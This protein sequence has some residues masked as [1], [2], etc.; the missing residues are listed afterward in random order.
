MQPSYKNQCGTV[1]AEING[2]V[3]ADVKCSHEMEV[4]DWT[5]ILQLTSSNLRGNPGQRFFALFRN[6]DNQQLQLSVDDPSTD[7]LWAVSDWFD[8]VPGEWQTWQFE[9][10]QNSD[11]PIMT[12]L[13]VSF[14]GVTV[15]S[16]SVP[17]ANVYA[18][19]DLD[20]Y[21]SNRWNIAGSAY[22][23][24]NFYYQTFPKI[25]AV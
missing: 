9:R 15:F 24:R 18:D 16:N 6:K 17:T 11:N 22:A 19:D 3:S 1:T 25:K 2:V 10:T 4:D 12:D 20:V 14:D 8:C 23:V 5:N 13:S 21:L 7:I